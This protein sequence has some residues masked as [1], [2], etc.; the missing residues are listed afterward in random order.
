MD[1]CKFCGSTEG[2][3]YSS[4]DKMH[5]VKC[6]TTIF[7]HFRCKECGSISIQKIPDNLGAYYNAYQLH[8]SWKPGVA[9]GPYKRM[10]ALS[11]IKEFGLTEKDR[12]VDYGC[13]DLQ[14]CLVLY[15]HGIGQ[16][17]KDIRGFDRFADPISVEG[18]IMQNT[19]PTD[20][21]FTFLHASHVF[22][23]SV[24]SKE[25]LQ[26]MSDMLCKGG[27]ALIIYPNPEA[28]HF[29]LFGENTLQLD[30]P[31]HTYMP[32]TRI[33]KQLAAETGFEVENVIQ[34]GGTFPLAGSLAYRD[35]LQFNQIHEWA[36]KNKALAQ[37][38]PGA[39][40]LFNHLGIGS[41]LT[42]ILKKV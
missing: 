4:V 37:G 10:Y 31:R 21:T 28:I 32:S 5:A 22:E 3:S 36:E 9:I 15:E 23:H 2:K 20:R 41:E 11:M 39:E 35:G 27:R 8:N 17:Q 14:V 12:V 19:V 26:E 13:A 42:V 34:R 30:A 38:L 7:T 16:D 33:V 18:I 6:D 25:T 1:L 24:N 40:L 29:D